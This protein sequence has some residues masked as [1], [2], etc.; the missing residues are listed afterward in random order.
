V[1]ETAKQQAVVDGRV[2]VDDREPVRMIDREYVDL[3]ARMTRHF[4]VDGP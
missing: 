2:D 4:G 3:A 1:T